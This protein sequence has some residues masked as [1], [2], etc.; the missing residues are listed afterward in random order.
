LRNKIID[1]WMLL[2]LTMLLIACS[3]DEI[4]SPDEDC[5]LDIYVYA[6]DRPIVTRADVGDIAQRTTA[7]SEVKTLQIWVFKHSDGTKVGYFGAGSG[8]AN[9]VPD[10]TFLNETGQQVYR[11]KVDKTFADAP[12]AVDVYVVANAA[13][14]ISTPITLN[15]NTS[16]AQLDQAMI[17]ETNFGTTN[18]VSSVP[19]EGLPMSAVAK[20]QPIYGSFPALRIGSETEMTKLQLTRAVSKLRFVLCRIDDTNSNKKLVSIDGI[21]LTDGATTPSTLIP[22][23]TY[24]MPGTY[25]YTNYVSGSIDYV[26]NNHPLTADNTVAEYYIPFVKDPLAYTYETQGAQEYEDLIDKAISGNYKAHVGDE[27]LKELGLTYLRESD[28]RLTG[29]IT[30][31][32]NENNS[33]TDTQATATFSMAN[34]GDFLRNHSWIVYVYYMDSKIYTLTVTHIGMRGWNPDPMEES[35]TVYNW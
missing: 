26:E 19:D 7:E 6:P 8:D 24:L 20:Q 22:E 25:S 2:L 23:K 4:V 28:K 1:R 13:S 12:E 32:Y 5:Y 34:P 21:Q 27:N 16:R 30:Y 15:G 17:S 31:T 33:L 29:T 3:G 18:L 11:M 14:Y 10:P 9:D 35:P